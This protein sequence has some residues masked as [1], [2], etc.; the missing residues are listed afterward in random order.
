VGHQAGEIARGF[1]IK[2]N[3]ALAIDGYFHRPLRR[4][5]YPKVDTAG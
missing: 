1:R 5:P 4:R 2:R 3:D